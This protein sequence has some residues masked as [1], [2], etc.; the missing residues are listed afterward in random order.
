MPATNKYNSTTINKNTTEVITDKLNSPEHHNNILTL[1][2]PNVNIFLYLRFSFCQ[3][4]PFLIITMKLVT[5]KTIKINL[6]SHF[7]S[8][9]YICNIMKNINSSFKLLKIII[10]RGVLKSFAIILNKKN[11]IILVGVSIY[12]YLFYSSF[13]YL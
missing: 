12:F 4:Y 11:G 10:L 9:H 7:F 2:I 6:I 5:D 13:D 3:I 8:T 1:V